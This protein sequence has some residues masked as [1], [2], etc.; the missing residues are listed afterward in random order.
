MPLGAAQK[1]KIDETVRSEVSKQSGENFHSTGFAYQSARCGERARLI[2][3]LR[4]PLLSFCQAP[5]ASVLRKKINPSTP[6]IRTLF[7]AH[8]VLSF[9]MN[10]PSRFEPWTLAW[11]ADSR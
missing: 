8:L 7:L 2:A 4:A 10:L 9:A 1:A 6:K 11:P 5:A 3:D